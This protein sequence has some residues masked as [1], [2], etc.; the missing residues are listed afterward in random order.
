MIFAVP[1]GVPTGVPVAARTTSPYALLRRPMRARKSAEAHSVRPA[2]L[3]RR[4]TVFL[5][6]FGPPNPP[7]PHSPHAPQ[8]PPFPKMQRIS[9]RQLM[10]LSAELT[11]REFVILETVEMLGLVTG[12]QIERLHFSGHSPKSRA[13]GRRRVVRRLVDAR[14]L[15][16]LP[17]RMG[18]AKRG[19][20]HHIYALDTAGVRLMRQRQGL[21]GAARPQ[22]RSLPGAQVL[23]HVLAVSELYVRLVEA[24][25]AHGFTVAAFAAEPA[26]WWRAES[27]TVIKPDAYAELAAHG[28]G[29]HWWI[30]VDRATESVP[31]VMRQ[32]A[33]YLDFAA[34]GQAGPA[35]VIPRV[36][37]TVP[38]NARC[39]ALSAAL[40]RLD[41]VPDHFITIRPF[42]AAVGFL[43]AHVHST[44]ETNPAKRG[45]Q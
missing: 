11:G 21:S 28:Y 5:W 45:D 1:L 39:A 10:Q 13:R 30:E 34:R 38:T 9:T 3:L 37:V 8:F 33:V 7:A 29:D 36:L 2:C 20:D 19:S 27:G 12:G 17:R 42:D 16:A 32:L 6:A 40:S 31:T 14:A 44:T 26:S 43:A 35:E 25:R 23:P 22:R 4:Q 41:G 15:Q 18:G 24:S